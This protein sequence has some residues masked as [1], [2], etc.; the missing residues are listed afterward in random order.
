MIACYSFLSYRQIPQGIIQTLLEVFPG[1]FISSVGFDGIFGY[2]LADPLTYWL[3]PSRLDHCY[4]FYCWDFQLV[5]LTLNIFV[6]EAS[7]N[8]WIELL[9]S[10]P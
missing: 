3:L 4:T 2:T 8:K 9:S 5:K 10:Q 1:V 7:L 6:L